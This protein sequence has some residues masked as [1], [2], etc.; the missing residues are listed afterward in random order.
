M[1]TGSI[2]GWEN[3]KDDI[4]NPLS[5]RNRDDCLEP[6]RLMEVLGRQHGIALHTADVNEDQH[7]KPDFSLYVESIDFVPSGAQKNYLIL[8]ETPLTVPRNLDLSYL[9]YFDTIFTW[10]TEYVEHGLTDAQGKH[11]SAGHFTKIWYPN[12]IP[13]ECGAAFQSPTFDRRPDRVCLIGSNRHANVF[14]G[15]ELYSERVKAIR[16]FEAHAPQDFKLYGN[17]WKVPQKRL[18]SLGKLRYRLEKILPWILGK[19][20]F[21]S[22]QGPAKTKYEVLS[23]TQF[24]ICFENA[25]DIPGYITEKIFDC[26]FAGCIP[27]YWGDADIAQSIPAECFIDFRQFASYEKLHQ[28]LSSLTAEQFAAYQAAARQFL[29][30][31]QFAPYSSQNFAATVVQKISRDFGLA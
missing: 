30:G 5:L 18:G 20:V 25:R 19:P 1:L 6:M 11:L 27:I 26:F 12:P 28:Y 9:A 3:G 4:F 8:Y 7:V 23:K 2:Y 21:T 14:D 29:M 16:W 15:R 24:C 31:P 13:Q 22:Y 10:N 17:G